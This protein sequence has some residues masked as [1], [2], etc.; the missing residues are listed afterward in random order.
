VKHAASNRPRAWAVVPAG[1]RGA[2]MGLDTP[3]QYLEVRGVPLL[4]HTLRAL[5]ACPRIEGLVLVVPAD[6]REGAAALL[7]A[8]GLDGGRI[9]APVAG[10][11]TRQD[12]VR[13]GLAEVPEGVDVVAIHDAVRPF[14]DPERLGA[15]IRRAAADGVGVVVGR[16][17]SDTIKRVDGAG[18]VLE[19]PDRARLWQAFT[20]QVFPVKMIAAAHD[21]AH[22]AGWR[23]TDD[24]ALVERAGGTVVM[25]EG[26]RE[27]LKVT[28][29]DDLLTAGAWLVGAT[30]GSPGGAPGGLTADR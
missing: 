10:G 28:T 29:P 17:A 2:R 24:A 1:G 18:R 14:P 4:V 16:P 20:P 22:R 19:S 3:K 25:V 15:A 13:R 7:A 12:S 27:A 6:D 26:G 9:A 8:H 5:L 21:D 30:G 23:G 11:A